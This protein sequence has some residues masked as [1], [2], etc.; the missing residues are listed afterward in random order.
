M[1]KLFVLLLNFLIFSSSA[2]AQRTDIYDASGRL[3]GYYEKILQ[4]M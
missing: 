4:V 1:K 2:I 3:T